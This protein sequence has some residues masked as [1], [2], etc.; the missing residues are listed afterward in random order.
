MPS[1]RNEESEVDSPGAPHLRDVIS[2]LINEL[3]QANQVACDWY[4]G[5]Q[6]SPVLELA[7]ATVELTVEV[8]ADDHGGLSFKV[9]GVGA[10]G[11]VQHTRSTTTKM[12]VNIVPHAGASNWLALNYETPFQ[13]DSAWGSDAPTEPERPS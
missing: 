6:G 4:R 12:V 8:A 9:F 13:P 3:R 1:G 11:G 10:D 2:A 5:H 7:G